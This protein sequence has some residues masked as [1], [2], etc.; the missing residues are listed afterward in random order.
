MAEHARAV[1]HVDGPV[2]HRAD[3]P[4]H[5]LGA[6]LAVG[7]ERHDDPGARVD[8]QPVA[9][10]QGGAAAQV[11]HVARHR[12]AVRARDVAR[13]VARAVVHHEH[14]VSSPHTVAGMRGSTWPMLSSSL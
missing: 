2:G 1:R 9:G 11:G 7:V 4:L 6:V 3:E 13:P 10:A 5:L 14:R 12:G 8:H